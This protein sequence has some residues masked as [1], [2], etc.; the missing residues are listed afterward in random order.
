MNRMAPTSSDELSN[1]GW[2]PP[3]YGVLENSGARLD[4]L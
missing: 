3:W 1:D 4:I 2:Q